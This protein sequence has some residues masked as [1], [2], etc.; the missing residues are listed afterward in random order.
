MNNVAVTLGDAIGTGLR[1]EAAGRVEVRTRLD[2]EI[3]EHARSGTTRSL[4][5]AKPQW[6]LSNSDQS[7]SH[8]SKEHPGRFV[9]ALSFGVAPL[10]YELIRQAWPI[11]DATKFGWRDCLPISSALRAAAKDF[12]E[13]PQHERQPEG[14]TLF[15]PFRLDPLHQLF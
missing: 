10:G 3:G 14:I 12:R 1:L 11:H 2:R 6:V 15:N 8:I 4:Q 5:P 9:G 13:D 7:P